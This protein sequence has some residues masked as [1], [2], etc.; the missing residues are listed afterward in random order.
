MKKTE[1]NLKWILTVFVISIVVANV[2][3]GRVIDT[4]IDLFGLRLTLSGGAITY[5]FSFLSTDI[6]GEI[7]G[8][9]KAKQFV[10][11]GFGGQLFSTV[12]ITITG[13]FPTTIIG[14]EEAYKTVLGQNWV[15][16]I[17]SM[18]A[19][20]FSQTWDVY[21]FHRI[22]NAYVNKFGTIKGGKWIWNNCST[23]TSQ[24]FDTAIFAIISYGLG[25][26]WI[27]TTEGRI[28]L[29]G[30]AVGQ[31]LLKACLALLDTPFFY[32][33]TRHSKTNIEENE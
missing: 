6:V 7:W 1:T 27:Y 17:G 33:F 10:K 24:I 15:F 20:C 12:L 18:C 29:V 4:G 25:F 8:K 32:F 16:F 26:G 5:A 14:M 31:Y 13:M 21:V 3:A 22:R 19:Y 23:L 11:Y 28:Q 30:V 9:E 2:C